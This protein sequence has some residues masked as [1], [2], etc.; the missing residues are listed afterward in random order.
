MI[1][2]LPLDGA[3]ASSQNGCVIELRQAASAAEIEQ[4]RGLFREY[5]RWVDEPC[6]FPTF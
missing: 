4:V 5:Q 1:A 2:P 6:C 3:A